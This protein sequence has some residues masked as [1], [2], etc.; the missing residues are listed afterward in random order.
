MN[1][2]M[3]RITIIILF[4][5]V[6]LIGI[7]TAV[8]YIASIEK[9]S[10]ESPITGGSDIS[11]VIELFIYILAVTLIII[12]TIKLFKKML[13]LLE[14][15]AV[16]FMSD[17]V[18]ELLFPF[19]VFNVIPIGTVMAI[20][21]TAAKMLKPNI[22]TQNT[23]LIFSTAGAGAIIG[24]SFSPLAIVF[25][26]L[27]LSAYDFISVFY[28]KHMVYMAKAMTERP[29]AFTASLP[30]AVGKGKRK[31]YAY[32]L[33]GGDLVVP[34]TLAVSSLI[35]YGPKAAYFVMVFSL[36]GLL[37]LFEFVMGKKGKALPALPPISAAACL[38]LLISTLI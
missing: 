31:A 5:S 1:K 17:I 9:G 10:L 12:I 20:L 16:F 6:Q 38:G 30:T 14:A 35:H 37:L 11:T 34:L 18:F 15:L 3:L 24:I 19:V 26:M 13:L 21:L 7:A 32:Q 4:V 36:F 8:R 27:L 33:G 28:T 25:F 23:A 29:T 2:Q 22:L